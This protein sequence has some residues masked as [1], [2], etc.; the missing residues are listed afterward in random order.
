M[1]V[2]VYDILVCL[3]FLLVRAYEHMFGTYEYRY[4]FIKSNIH[5]HFVHCKVIT[6]RHLPK[7]I[8]H[9]SKSLCSIEP[10]S[11][12]VVHEEMYGAVACGQGGTQSG[13]RRV[14]MGRSGA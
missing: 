5:I 9:L 6:A 8:D 10:K 1:Y 4:K 13:A 7:S 12:G 2:R 3:V 11:S 14:P